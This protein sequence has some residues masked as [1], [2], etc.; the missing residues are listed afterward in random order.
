MIDEF[1]VRKLSCKNEG[2][3]FIC[4]EIID[5]EERYPKKVVDLTL[6]GLDRITISPDG[7]FVQ[8]KEPFYC[9]YDEKRGILDCSDTEL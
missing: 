4:S 2:N 6:S 8:H 9:S 3:L 5:K 1:T 7:V